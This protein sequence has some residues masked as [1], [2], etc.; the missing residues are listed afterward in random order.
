[1]GSCLLAL[2]DE[3]VLRRARQVLQEQTRFRV[4]PFSGEQGDVMRGHLALHFRDLDAAE[5]HYLDGLEWAQRPDVRLGL[6][7]GRCL[8]GLADVAE[9]QGEH[10]LALEHLEGAAAKFAEYSATLYLDQVLA[11][12][13]FLKA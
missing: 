3:T 6:V 10:A 8:R 12:K 13:A 7:E 1:M 2:A 5:R 4:A 9:A 11:T